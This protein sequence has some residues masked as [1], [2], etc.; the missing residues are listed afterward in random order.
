MSI[1][2]AER[3]ARLVKADAHGMVEALEENSLL[4]K[5]CLREAELDLLGK[6][7]R[8]EALAR[9]ERRL[10]ERGTRLRR[11]IESLDRDVQLALENDQE[12]LARFAIRRLLPRRREC[13]T[14]EDERARLAEAR[15]RLAERLGTQQE[16]L[17]ELRSRVRARLARPDC[18][19]LEPGG[20]GVGPSEAEVDLEL[21]RRRRAGEPR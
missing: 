1:G 5:Q 8:V 11:E 18:A 9:E 12:E 7:A 21:L 14:L 4:L 2:F 13:E 20:E 6:R 16:Q 17:E 3:V 15:G 19:E 10:E